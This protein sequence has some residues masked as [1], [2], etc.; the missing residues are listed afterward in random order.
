MNRSVS[1]GLEWGDEVFRSLWKLFR[2]IK[3]DLK[4]FLYCPKRSADIQNSCAWGI[5]SID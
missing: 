4:N 3:W 1:N 5:K 2:R